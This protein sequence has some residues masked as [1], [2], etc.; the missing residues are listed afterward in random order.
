MKMKRIHLP[1]LFFLLTAIPVSGQDARPDE[2]ALFPNVQDTVERNVL[3]GIAFGF[4]VKT[5]RRS[6]DLSAIAIAKAIL[7]SERSRHIK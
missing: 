1:F 6:G 5:L 7:E 3:H 4:D 2:F